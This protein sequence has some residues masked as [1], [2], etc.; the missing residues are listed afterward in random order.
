MKRIEQ[1]Q[2]LSREHHHSLTLAQKAIKTSETQDL[3]A[4]TLLCEEIVHDYP[5]VWKVHFKIEEDSIFKHYIEGTDELASLCQSLQ[6]EHRKMDEYY[7]QM[8]EGN[9]RVLKE[10]GLLLKKHTRT[11][12]RE[13]FPLLEEVMSQDELNKVLQISQDYRASRS[14]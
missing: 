1:L 14:A 13:L 6:Q 2:E 7:E 3:E 5:L 12:E 8:K 4:V 11:E 9:Y 10:F